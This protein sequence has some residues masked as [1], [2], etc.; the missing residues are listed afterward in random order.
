MSD[1][2]PAISDPTAGDAITAALDAE[3][4]HARA[5]RRERR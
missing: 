5:Q 2:A 3:V 1:A 4:A